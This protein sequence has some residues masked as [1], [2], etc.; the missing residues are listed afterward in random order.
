MGVNIDKAGGDDLAGS[1]DFLI[2]AARD[3]PDRG[4]QSV[5]H[6]Y[7]ADKARCS[8]AINDGAAADDQIKLR[9]ILSPVCAGECRKAG[10]LSSGVLMP[11]R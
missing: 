10:A 3:L 9:H 11:A 7:I 1:V 8:G 4:D 2:G 5:L 6:G